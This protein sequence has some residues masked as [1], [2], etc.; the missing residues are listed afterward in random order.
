MDVRPALCAKTLKSNGQRMHRSSYHHL[1]EDEINS[2][3]QKEKHQLFDKVVEQKLGEAA[4]SS[5]FGEGYETPT[6][7][8]YADDNGDGSGHATD[9]DDEPT[10]LTFDKYLEAEVVLPKGDDM[11]AS[12][13]VGRKRD[14]DG[15]PIGREN[16]NPILDT[17]VYEVEFVDGGCAEF[18]GKCYCREHVCTV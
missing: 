11:V 14:S 13:V 9:A 1:T 7:E 16:K 2:P 8:L 4:Q 12:K 3:G 5:D 10:P 6:Y 17:C 15:E 18:W